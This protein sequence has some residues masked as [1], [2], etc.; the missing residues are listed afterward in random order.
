[1]IIDEAGYLEHFGV[2]GM[3]WGHR[4][5]RESGERSPPKKKLTPEQRQRRIRIAFAVASGAIFVGQVMLESRGHKARHAKG[6]RALQNERSRQEFADNVVKMAGKTK[7]SDIRPPK[8]ARKAIAEM[9]P[10][11]KK[12][13]SEFSAKQS[14]INKGANLDL[15]DLYEKGQVPLHAREYLS[16]WEIEL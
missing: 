9:S 16:A 6:V 4:K 10:E 8:A 2:K 12:F 5:Q 13:I 7:V 15:K 3:R 1:M 14:L 11:T